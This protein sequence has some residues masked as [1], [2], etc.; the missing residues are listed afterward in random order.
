MLLKTV[1]VLC[2]RICKDKTKSEEFMKKI[3]AAYESLQ[4]LELNDK[5]SA[6]N[7][8]IYKDPEINMEAASVD[9][10]HRLMR[11]A[12]DNTIKKK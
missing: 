2:S 6:E 4:A 3:E 5:G 7:T 9:K 10:G 1:S 8:V 11:P 12:E